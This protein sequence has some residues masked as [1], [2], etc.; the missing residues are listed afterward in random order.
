MAFGLKFTQPAHHR[1]N[2]LE[3]RELEPV[4]VASIT[5]GNLHD[6]SAAHELVERLQDVVIVAGKQYHSAKFHL[7]IQ[8]LGAQSCLPKRKG[9]KPT[10]ASLN[11]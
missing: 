8:N 10:A 5:P 2:S 9:P 3:F 6:I 1:L 11:E 4:S 7:M